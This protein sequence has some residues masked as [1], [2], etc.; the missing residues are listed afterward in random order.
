[1]SEFSILTPSE[2]VAQHLHAELIRGRWQGTMPGA[3][4]LAGELKI[5]PKTAWLALKQLEREGVLQGQGPGRRRKILLAENR[6]TPALRVAILDYEP[7]DQTEEWSVAMR[8]HL[9]EEGHSAFFAEKS[10]TELGMDVRAVT[11]LVE[12]TPTDAWVVCSGSRDILSWFAQQEAP[13]FAMFGRRRGLPIAGV[14]PDKGQAYRSAA[15]RLMDLGHQRIV[16]LAREN[17]RL[18]G[19][20]RAER[21]VLKE[22]EANGY[23][24]GSYNFPDWEDTPEGLQRVLDDLFRVTP[25]TALIIDE[26]F[27]FH[28]A[29]EHLAQHGIVAPKHVSLICT[30]PDLTF[31]WCK[32][33]VAHIRWDHRPVV[34][35]VVRWAHQ[36]AQGNGDHRQSF[37]K[38]EF[39]DGGTVGEVPALL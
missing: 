5:D 24:T 34:R 33:S 1:M 19:A 14:G 6:A 35:R 9:T 27:L 16:L 31:G 10:L 8:H 12:R 25:P 39:V 32:P 38:A 2:Q 18:G 17:R 36:V 30:D 13:A 21:A 28:A 7:L 22:I 37:T 4:A 26:A 11:K 29:R 3:P 20:G 15:K 23:P